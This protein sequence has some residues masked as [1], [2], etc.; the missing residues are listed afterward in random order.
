[1]T[2]PTRTL[3]VVVFLLTSRAAAWSHGLGAGHVRHHHAAARRLM[4]EREDEG[5]VADVGTKHSGYNVLGTELSCCCSDVGGSGIGTGF[6][7]NGLCATGDMDMGRHTVCVRVTDDF[8]AY[9][10]SVGNDLSTPMPQYN[11]P[12]LNEGDIWCLCAQRWAQAYNAGK[13][14]KLFLRATHEKTLDYIP[15][16]VLRI[17]AID[18]AEASAVMDRL[19]IQRRLL[20]EMMSK[21]VTDGGDSFQ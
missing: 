9:S 20:D 19:N 2:R 4:A 10:K 12:G 17:F 3:I 15:L 8:L 5:D 1:M 14:P 13:A 6:Y 21:G 7:R 18:A 16:D 11:F